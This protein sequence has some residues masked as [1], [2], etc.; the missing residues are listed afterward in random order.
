MQYVIKNWRILAAIVLPLPI[1]GAL[2]L[3]TPTEKQ[4][5][6]KK[7]LKK[8]KSEKCEEPQACDNCGLRV[9]CREMKN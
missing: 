5:Q 4:R 1:A 3:F 7:V 8:W 2:I 6:Q 9:V